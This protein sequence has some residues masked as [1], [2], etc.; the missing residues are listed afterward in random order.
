MEKNIRT[1]VD[2]QLQKL[3]SSNSL[4]GEEDYTIIY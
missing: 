4:R 1:Q 3:I 2:K